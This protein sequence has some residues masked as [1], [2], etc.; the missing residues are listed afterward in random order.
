MQSEEVARG[1]LLHL[2]D[3]PALQKRASDVPTGDVDLE[4]EPILTVISS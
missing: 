1:L 2:N 4:L 3:P